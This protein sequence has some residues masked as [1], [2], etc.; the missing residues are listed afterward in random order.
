M[1]VF[2]NAKIN[3]GLSVIERRTDGYHNIESI[4]F[5]IPLCDVLEFVEAPGQDRHAFAS[6]GIDVECKPDANLVMKCVERLG[7]ESQLPPLNIF[8]HKVIPHGAGLGGGSS[9]A[10]FMLSALNEFL[11]LGFSR[12]QL[13]AVAAS[14]GSDCP[15]F[16]YNSACFVTGRGEV[17]TPVGLNLTGYHLLLVKPPVHVSTARAYAGI[18]PARPRV[19][20]QQALQTRPEE[21][22]FFLNNDFEAVV[23]KVYPEIESLKRMMYERGAVYAAMSGSGSAVFGLFSES[24]YVQEFPKDCFVWSGRL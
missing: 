3:L 7:L 19:P 4:F 20:V 18:V 11:G 21:W 22:R 12:E 5:P 2:P 17:L 15:F 6:S 24:P 16:L 8:L 23:F 1:V 10:A 14:I 9:D 13:V